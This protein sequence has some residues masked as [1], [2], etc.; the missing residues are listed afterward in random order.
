MKEGILLEAGFD[1]ISPNQKITIS[2]WAYDKAI[3]TE[4]IRISDNRAI[5]IS[6]Y[7][8]GYTFVEKLQTIA[9]KFRQEQEDRTQKPNYMR[10]YYDIYCLLEHPQVLGFIRT[11]EYAEHKKRRFPKVDFEYPLAE[12][13][14]FMLSD[15]KQRA[16][17]RKRYELTKALY[18][19]GQPDFDEVLER[20]K[21]FIGRL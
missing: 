18:Y 8:P 16:S 5:D 12:N 19:R 10:Q 21:E 11:G 4:S 17:F 20:I 15:S 14:A 6:C 9:T 13:E 3:K 2:S 7:H 1:T